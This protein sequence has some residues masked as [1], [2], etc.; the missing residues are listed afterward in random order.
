MA[1]VIPTH[2]TQ[3]QLTEFKM[4]YQKHFNIELSDDEAQRKG[5]T[6]L[7]FMTCVIEDNE[8]FFD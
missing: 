5:V 7:Q 6:F 8:A 1:L 4:L 3:E 2:L